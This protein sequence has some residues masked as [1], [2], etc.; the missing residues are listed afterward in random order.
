M[1]STSTE[2]LLTWS[3]GLKNWQRDA[4]RRLVSQDKLSQQDEDQVLAILKAEHGIPCSPPAP[5]PIPLQRDHLPDYNSA[6][7]VRL[8]AIAN[9]RN[10][11][12]I[13]TVSRIDFDAAGLSVVYGENGTGKSGYIRILRNACRSRST[14]TDGKAIPILSDIYVGGEA[15]PARAEIHLSVDG[16]DQIFEWEDGSNSNPSLARIAVFDS[17]AAAVYVDDSNHIAFLPFHLDLFFKLNATCVT[18][19]RRLEQEHDELKTTLQ[20]IV[21]EVGANTKAAEFL[22][23]L[24]AD[25]TEA[26]IAATLNWDKAQEDELAN[27][28][29]DLDTS[30]PTVADL[31]S[32]AKWARA[33]AERMQ[34]LAAVIS[35]EQVSDIRKVLADTKEARLAADTMA[36]GAFS[37]DPVPGVGSE[38][39][40]RMYAAAR[41]Y[42]VSESGTD[43]PTLLT[44][45]GAHCPLCQQQ[46]DET[47][48]KRLQRF[49]AFVTGKLAQDADACE[50]AY[51]LAF[52][53]ILSAVPQIAADFDA[54]LHQ[55][56]QRHAG[57]DQAVRAWIT[58]HRSRHD[59][60]V[61][62]LTS[63]GLGDLPPEPDAGTPEAMLSLAEQL[64]AERDRVAAVV[65]EDQRGRLKSQVCEL[66]ARKQLS[67]LRIAVERRVTDLQIEAA[68]KKCCDATDTRA[69]TRKAGEFS[70][71]YLTPRVTQLF[72][73][74]TD[75]L[76]IH[77]IKPNVERKA[78]RLNAQYRVGL[79]AQ[80][81]CRTSDVLSEGEQR[82]LALASFLAEIRAISDTA[83]IVIDDPVSSL[84]LARS[85]R[86]AHRLAHEATQ[87]Q[88]IVFTHSLVFYHQLLGAAQAAGIEPKSSAIFRDHASTGL[89]DPAGAPWAGLP[90]TKRVGV[91]KDRLQRT[92]K[93]SQ[94]S[95]A[96]Y[97]IEAKMLY[98]RLRDAWERLVEEK[99]FQ[100]VVTRFGQGIE[101]Q[102]LRYVHVSDDLYRRVEAGMTKTSIYSHDNPAAGTAPIPAPD[103]IVADLEEILSTL[104]EIDRSN[105]EVEKRRKTASP[106]LK[107]IPSAAS[108][109]AA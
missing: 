17:R 88:V 70:D 62:A 5:E 90:V 103:E 8:K 75:W 68:L 34:T 15:S 30:P 93:L 38:T 97:Q 102:K 44:L 51:Q 35:D 98:G 24:S 20:D 61:R 77:H 59:A 12:R 83:P 14:S 106:A 72:E 81:K 76:D 89:V 26:E 69:I 36:R 109:P 4:L 41:E 78:D 13:A 92:R 23:S 66:E 48:A 49:E 21:G 96:E 42:L 108:A 65:G 71:R 11:N 104:K 82:A 73:E 25:T 54:R 58:A 67:L 1:V 95:P 107:A 7:A 10:A 46:L 91:L 37:G 55:V 33:V 57:L 94:E 9:V 79:Q 22:K 18:L 64:I 32:L 63:S 85:F 74:E 16:E 47:A 100:G 3:A 39:W 99:L 40:R 101:T 87:R 84:D 60:V 6:D 105:A 50:T 27:A 19:R 80:M 29:K 45:K 86:V 31:D 52:E 53:K 28:R 2:E 56:S 43:F